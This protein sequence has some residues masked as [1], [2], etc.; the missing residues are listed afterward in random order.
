LRCYDGMCVCA[1]A[2]CRRKSSMPPDDSARRRRLDWIPG[3]RVTAIDNTLPLPILSSHEPPRLTVLSNKSLV[4]FPFHP[5]LASPSSFRLPS[6]SLAS[7]FCMLS[8]PWLITGKPI[9][10][11]H[12]LM[13]QCTQLKPAGRDLHFCTLFI[14]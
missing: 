7:F 10:G 4:T 8:S 1:C 11:V 3:S 9:L 14:V 6:L 12:I 5:L 13:W 2:V